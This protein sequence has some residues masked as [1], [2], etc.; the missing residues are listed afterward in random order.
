MLVI[1][2]P[3]AESYGRLMPIR[4]NRSDGIGQQRLARRG[5]RRFQE[6]HHEH[7]QLGAIAAEVHHSACSR[8]SAS[9]SRVAA[10]PVGA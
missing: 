9:R 7:V 3:H 6:H 10:A 4:E 5:I 1:S 2:P 8:I